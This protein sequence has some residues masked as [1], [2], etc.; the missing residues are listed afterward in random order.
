MKRTRKMSKM[1]KPMIS[2]LLLVVLAAMAIP[3]FAQ[4]STRTKTVT[5]EQIN[6]AYRVGNPYRS[7]VSNISVDLQAGQVVISST[8]TFRNNT[9][10]TV[11]VITPSIS[12]GRVTWTVVSAT[13]NGEE[14]SAELLAQI[15]ASITSA[16]RNYI[17]N[18]VGQGRVTDVTITD[19]DITYML[20]SRR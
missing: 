17:R 1:S 8:H 5:E 2:L 18:Q 20:E 16:W 13:A 10:D 14:A 9:Y 12:N 3:A 6:S 19:T 7:R 11:A 15:N 4:S